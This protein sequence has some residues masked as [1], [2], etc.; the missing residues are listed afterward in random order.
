MEV[1]SQAV[2][3]A[4][5]CWPRKEFTG[6]P[7]CLPRGWYAGKPRWLFSLPGLSASL[8]LHRR[9][10]LSSVQKEPS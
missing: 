2:L 8:A 10:G 9:Q 5:G 7:G 4:I 6:W 1:A 3:C